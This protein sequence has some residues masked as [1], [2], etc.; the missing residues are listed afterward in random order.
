MEIT[1]IIIVLFMLLLIYAIRKGFKANKVD[2]GH[3]VVNCIDG[4][5]RIY[6]RRFQRFQHDE[7]KI[8]DTGGVLV[9]C[10]HVSG[11]E[12][13]LLLTACKRPLR[14]M[15]AVEEYNRPILNSLFRIVGCI[16]V[17]R[18]GRPEIAFRAAIKALEKGEAVAI[19]PHGG[20]H[21]DNCGHRPIKAGVLKLAQ[22]SQSKIIPTRVT[23]IRKPGNSFIPLFLRGEVRLQVFPHLP[24]DFIEQQDARTL[25]GDLLVGK[26]PAI[27]IEG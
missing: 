9:V 19:F 18:Q 12:P 25:L 21:T 8:P 16:P 3:S 24:D 10:N 20:I 17:E 26:I 11:L 22:L 7:M 4:W 13:L 14:F 6:C 5:M 1:L 15:I 23:G 27:E 2:W